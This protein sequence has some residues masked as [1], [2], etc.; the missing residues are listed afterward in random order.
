MHNRQNVMEVILFIQ[1]NYRRAFWVYPVV[2]V[3]GAGCRSWAFFLTALSAA[4]CFSVG[5]SWTQKYLGLR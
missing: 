2:A 4:S 1:F 5:T 3:Y